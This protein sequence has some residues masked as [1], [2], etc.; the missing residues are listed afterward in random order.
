MSLL[1]HPS[2][3]LLFVALAGLPLVPI[4]AEDSWWT[5]SDAAFAQ[6]YAKQAT[7]PTI[8]DQSSVAWMLFARAN[9]RVP[10]NGTTLSQ[11][12][13]WPSNDDTFSPAVKAFVVQN[14]VR[15]RPHLQAPKDLR[16]NAHLKLL[17]LPP[18]GGGEEVT[19]NGLS[20]GY[21]REKG[22]Y[23][24]GGI[25]AFFGSP[26]AQVNFPNGAVE[27]KASWAS[28]PVD[29]AYQVTDTTMTPPAVYSLLGLHIMAKIAPTPADPFTSENP[30][31]FWTTFE[32]KGNP[33]W[34]H[35]QTLI[36]YRDALPPGQ[37]Q[38]LLGQ[39]GLGSTAFANYLCNGTQI[40]FS[41]DK[42]P[43][44]VLGNT[45]MEAGFAIPP[46][47]PITAWT[48]WNSSCHSCHATSS[49]TSAGG[50][51]PFQND[52]IGKLVGIN[53][54]LTGYRSFDFVWSIDFYARP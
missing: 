44:I 13:V 35:A 5:L 2:S 52:P 16:F 41:D 46:G 32:F 24:I 34:S 6:Q 1:R 53:P 50:M 49:G 45:Q 26:S 19:R 20:Y 42:N 17:A 18:A 39:A 15:T 28:G 27:V 9:Q 43:A 23:T 4:H 51:Y 31:W 8:A 40:R 54:P 33:G 12:E 11:W 25:K 22:L 37:A 14:K 38:S 3:A 7:S 29:G 21:I 30:S 36:T 47:P 10:F 48:K